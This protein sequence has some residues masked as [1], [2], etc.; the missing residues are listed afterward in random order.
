MKTHLGK[1]HVHCAAEARAIWV[2]LKVNY[3]WTFMLGNQ[4]PLDLDDRS[5]IQKNVVGIA[6]ISV[7]ATNGDTS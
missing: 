4:I 3:S 6:H 1:C 5:V 2:T 7:K